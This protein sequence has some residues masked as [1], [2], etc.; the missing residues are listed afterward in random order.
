MRNRASAGPDLYINEFF[1]NGSDVLLNYIHTLFNKVFEVGYFPE[2]WSEGFIVPIFK[3]GDK[4]E[5]SNYRGITLLSTV[6]KL[7]TRI[8]NNRLN[9]WA[10]EYNIYIEAQ[11]G[12]RTNMSTID[13][14]FILNALISHNLN[15]NTHLYCAFIDF[16]KAFDYVVRNILWYKL[17]KEGV[18]GKILDIIKSMYNAVKSKVKHENALSEAFTCNIGVRQG[19]CL[20]PFLFSMYLNDLEEELLVKGAN[21]IDIGMIKLFLLLYADDIVLFGE[22]PEEL[23]N[24]LKLL[25]DYCSRWKLT[26]NT[27]KTKIMIFKKSGRLP[28]NLRFTYNGAEIEIVNKFIYL[29][30]HSVYLRRFLA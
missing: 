10:E 12:F 5:V 20:S 6:G 14:I 27:S 16:T 21:G 11:A 7:F 28:A 19:E 9:S 13:N 22:S 26:V 18:R 3:K 1:K 23:Q 30:R 15:S 29:F 8:L 25:E 2:I 4:N 24:T 17:I